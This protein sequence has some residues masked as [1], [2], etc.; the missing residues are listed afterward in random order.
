MSS[1][2]IDL[3]N[4]RMP[5][6]EKMR[7]LVKEA[8]QADDGWT[9]DRRE[10]FDNMESE[11]NRLGEQAEDAEREEKAERY[12]DA[13]QAGLDEVRFQE[14]QD[15]L[16]K[17]VVTLKMRENAFRAWS[18]GDQPGQIKDEWRDHAKACDVDIHSPEFSVNLF[19]RQARSAEDIRD[20]IKENVTY[21]ATTAQSLTAAAG[22]NTV[23]DDVSL[24]GALESALL[25]FG[26]QRN[27]SRIIRTANGADLPIPIADDTTNSAAILTEASTVTIQ[28]LTFGLQTLKAYK[29][30]SYVVSSFELLSDTAIDLVGYIGQQLG[31][32]IA[33]GTNEHLTNGDGSSKPSG[34]INKAP[35]P[36]TNTGP[37]YATLVD[38]YHS[39]D[40]LYRASGSFK[41]QMSD[42]GI[43]R[44]SKT[45]RLE[46]SS[47]LECF[48]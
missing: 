9:P 6:A 38:L 31:E 13:T 20:M 18:F 41:W 24:M 2:S 27:A 17:N 7:E 10:K 48:A 30:S 40:P 8:S 15:S 42:G 36:V 1:R 23:S 21:R 32:R 26:G 33:R 19:S 39:V 37:T 14:K 4:Q 47:S 5:L 35:A 29:Y 45:G 28:S 34:A 11:I 25:A 46:W 16:T 43:E 44:S 3:L 12:N 22:G